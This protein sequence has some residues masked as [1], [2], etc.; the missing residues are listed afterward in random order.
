MRIFPLTASY[1]AALPHI[2]SVSPVRVPAAV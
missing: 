1:M 2:E